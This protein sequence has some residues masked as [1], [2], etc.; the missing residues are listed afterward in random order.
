[1]VQFKRNYGANVEVVLRKYYQH[2]VSPK[3]EQNACITGGSSAARTIRVHAV[4]IRL[5]LF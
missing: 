2:L 5:L 3:M 1:V 4:V